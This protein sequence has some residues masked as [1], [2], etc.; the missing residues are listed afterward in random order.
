YEALPEVLLAA[1]LYSVHFHQEET[2]WHYFR[3]DALTRRIERLGS[4]VA[5]LSEGE[6]S[7]AVQLYGAARAL[8]GPPAGLIASGDH[9]SELMRSRQRRAQIDMT[10]LRLWIGLR[11]LARDHGPLRISEEVGE[12]VRRRWVWPLPPTQRYVAWMRWMRVWLEAMSLSNWVVADT[13]TGSFS[14]PMDEQ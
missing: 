2:L 8:G 5:D 3:L 12:E 9:L 6:L 14:P 10:E 4:R 7:G 13:E 1:A 11:A